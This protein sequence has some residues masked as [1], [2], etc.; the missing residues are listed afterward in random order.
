MGYNVLSGS[1]SVTSVVTSGSFIGD[2]SQLENVQQFEL[3]N[4]GDSRIPFYKLVSGDYALD[5]DNTFTFN[6]SSNVLTVPAV[7]CSVG[8]K[9]SSPIS[10]TIAGPSSFVALDSNGNLVITAS[11]GGANGTG[12]SNSLQFHTTGG[13]ISGSSNL[14]FASNILTANCGLVFSRKQVTSTITASATDH[15]IGVS[16]SSAIIVQMPGA[17][18]LSSGQLFVIKDEAGNAGNYNITVK[19]SGSQTID[20]ESAIILESPFASVNLYTNGSNKFFIY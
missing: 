14:L 7:T 17:E 4:A 9:L 5:A 8:I 20:G 3:F 6:N 11:L 10:G 2:G 15:F 18:T 16:A 13:Q 19:S 12:P 1:T